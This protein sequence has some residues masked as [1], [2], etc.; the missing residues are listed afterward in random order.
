MH[1]KYTPGRMIMRDRWT[2][3]RQQQVQEKEQKLGIKT[4]RDTWRRLTF[5]WTKL[6]EGQRAVKKH[7][8]GRREPACMRESHLWRY[9]KNYYLRN[10]TADICAPPPTCRTAPAAN[11]ACVLPSF[12]WAQLAL[13]C[14]SLL[15]NSLDREA[16]ADLSLASPFVRWAEQRLR[17]I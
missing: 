15:F 3:S 6:K 8:W 2:Q 14:H 5:K 12:K 1:T 16:G 17:S 7:L 4:Q 10:Q 11:S 13:C 9:F